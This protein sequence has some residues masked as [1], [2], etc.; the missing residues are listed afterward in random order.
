M[1]IES[2][3]RLR[4][5]NWAGLSMFSVLGAWVVGQVIFSAWAL[6]AWQISFALSALLLLIIL[7]LTLATEIVA[8]LMSLVLLLVVTNSAYYSGGPTGANTSLFLLIPVGA[9]SVAGRRGL[10]WTL[11]ALAA[12]ITMEWA[13]KTDYVFPY[14]VADEEQW[15]DALLTWITSMGVISFLIFQFERSRDKAARES[16]AA[17]E[18]A[19]EASRVKS[20]FVANISHEIRTPLH[21]ILGVLDLV[22]NEP[23]PSARKKL[24]AVAREA[25][26]LL[27][28]VINDVLDLSR[29]EADKIEIK[30]VDFMIARTLDQVVFLV[31]EPARQKGLV[32]KQEIDLGLPERI[33]GDSVHLRQV[34]LNLMSNAVNYTEKGRVTL[35]LSC[36]QPGPEK[37]RLRFEVEDSGIGMDAD[38]IDR[39]FEPF[40]QADGTSTRSHGGAGLGLAI[41][42]KLVWLMGGELL[43][44]SVPG[45]GSTFWFEIDVDQAASKPECPVHRAPQEPA[46]EESRPV[47]L[48]V[49]DNAINR[50]LAVV[51]LEKI[52]CLV[53]VADDGQTAL[54][55]IECQEFDLVLMDCQMPVMDGLEATRRIRAGEQ[56][57]GGAHIPIVALTAHAMENERQIC[58]EAGM[59]DYLSKPFT[60][61]D[62]ERIVRK[63]A[64]AD[65]KI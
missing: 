30:P 20:Q 14:L 56:S 19:E 59:D 26:K 24:T 41:S 7:R 49:E 60:K 39:V 50:R 6:V 58:F 44:S 16:T 23:D 29:I 34:L 11:P 40:V 37:V 2:R 13:R 10:W 53:S 3:R 32:L 4:L 48:V 57:A 55:Q 54:S 43:V 61:L 33:R 63:W 12:V 8:H 42:R 25:G 21:G 47:V 22:E 62:I 5:I 65:G 51:M 64:R 9:V 1:D 27:I 17:R 28:D 45:Q 46:P 35:R 31:S 15:L 52:G 36:S 38:Q 18:I